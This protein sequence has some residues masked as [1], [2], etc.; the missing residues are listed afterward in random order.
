[1]EVA[2]EKMQVELEEEMDVDVYPA[3]APELALEPQPCCAKQ[4][5]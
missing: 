3:V 4:C 2:V 1:M 5:S